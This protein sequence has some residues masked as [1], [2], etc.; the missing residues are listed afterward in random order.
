MAAHA[1]HVGLLPTC[2]RYGNLMAAISE[3]AS[4]L[5]KT[6]STTHTLFDLS[7]FYDLSARIFF[8][9]TTIAYR[10]HQPAALPD[11]VQTP[12]AHRSVPFLC[13]TGS[14]VMS[15]RVGRLAAGGAVGAMDHLR[16]VQKGSPENHMLEDRLAELVRHKHCFDG[17]IGG[18][19]FLRGCLDFFGYLANLVNSLADPDQSRWPVEPTAPDPSE[20]AEFDVPHTYALLPGYFV[21]DLCDFLLFLGRRTHA[22]PPSHLSSH[23]DS[24]TCRLSQTA[25]CQPVPCRAIE[26]WFRAGVLLGPNAEPIMRLLSTLLC[27]DGHLKNPFVRAKIN[28]AL[29]DFLPD[30]SSAEGGDGAPPDISHHLL[31]SAAVRRHLPLSLLRFYV[32]IEH[33]G[34]SHAFYDKFN[35]RQHATALLLF[36]WADGPA[37]IIQEALVKKPGTQTQRHGN[38]ASG[39]PYVRRLPIPTVVLFWAAVCWIRDGVGRAVARQFVKAENKLFNDL[40]YLLDETLAKLEVIHGCQQ[41]LKNPRAIREMSEVPTPAPAPALSFHKASNLHRRAIDQEAF[42]SNFATSERLARIFMSLA[43]LSMKLLVQA[44]RFVPDL[45]LEGM[46]CS[47]LAAMLNYFTLKLVGPQAAVV[48][49]EN[50]GAYGWDPDELLGS[51]VDVCLRLADSHKK[52]DYCKAVAAVRHGPPTGAHCLAHTTPAP[53]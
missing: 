23:R 20:D 52:Q 51:I 27:A 33:T 35:A 19:D 44:A 48:Q 9:L 45:L 18:S 14:A 49:V 8:F 10:H 53:E 37:S 5:R 2:A 30:R 36:L 38:F 42:Q 40:T 16:R 31:H 6:D 21:E 4:R 50:P 11:H 24:P 17:Q 32:D 43:K 3:T 1:L 41:T 26:N 46:L 47:R 28:E 13:F 25:T 39:R 7:A 12:C 22:H 34:D 15:C 29:A